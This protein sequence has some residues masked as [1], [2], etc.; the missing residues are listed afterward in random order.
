M[1]NGLSG[2]PLTQVLVHALNNNCPDMV[3]YKLVEKLTDTNLNVDVYYFISARNGCNK[4]AYCSPVELAIQLRRYDIV[5]LLVRNNADPIS[6]Q[7]NALDGVPQL[8]DEY[9]SFGTN[10]YMR[11]LFHEH[12]IEI[13]G[14]IQRVLRLDIFNE[15][16]MEMFVRASRHPAHA[17][18]TSGCEEF[19]K[20]FIRIYESEN[21]L[22][23]KDDTGRTALEISAELGFIDSIEILLN[24]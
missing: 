16:C 2:S 3:D 21:Y 17:I 19:I 12:Q 23:V 13:T 10:S 11:W 5:K 20:E 7:H 15:T 14:F 1:G 4:R 8:F 9:Y 24:L 6:P 22:T 18:L